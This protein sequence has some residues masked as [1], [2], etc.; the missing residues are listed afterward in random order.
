MKCLKCFG[1]G[2]ECPYANPLSE[3]T[4]C[5]DYCR[6][7]NKVDFAE[8]A[9][10]CSENQVYTMR[11]W[12]SGE[13]CDPPEENKEWITITDSQRE[14]LAIIVCRDREYYEN[15]YPNVVLR[16]IENAKKIATALNYAYQNGIIK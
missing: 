12:D 4:F 6:N 15:K 1:C 16:K 10:I 11:Y 3:W 13:E 5:S 2:R 14:E 9:G 7:L 8:E